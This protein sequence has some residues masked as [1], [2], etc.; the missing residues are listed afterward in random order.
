MV[1]SY[2]LD[3]LNGDSVVVLG[4]HPC[5]VRVRVR[6]RAVA[7]GGVGRLGAGGWGREVGGGRLGGGGQ[8]PV[9]AGGDGPGAGDRP[10][11]AAAPVRCPPPGRVAR[12][13]RRGAGAGRRGAGRQTAGGGARGGVGGA[14]GRPRPAQDWPP[15]CTRTHPGDSAAPR[16]RPSRAGP[17]PALSLLDAGGLRLGPPAVAGGVGLPGTTAAA[18]GVARQSPPSR[19]S[20]LPD[21]LAFPGRAS[22][23][24]LLVGGQSIR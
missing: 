14:T 21:S 18:A 7:G 2:H 17:A 15:T 5:R 1:L 13:I 22:R 12:I 6:V 8:P 4:H 3:W 9:P 19:S 10:A 16:E 24:G 20:R 23:A 11:A